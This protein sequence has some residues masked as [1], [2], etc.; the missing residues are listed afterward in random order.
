MSEW[1]HVVHS[2][3]EGD[4]RIYVNGQAKGV[5]SGRNSLLDVRRPGRMWVGGWYDNYSFVGQIDEVR[6][7]K[8]ARSAHWV[9]LAYENQKP[10]QTLVGMPVQP[11]TTLAVSPPEV[12]LDEGRSTVLKASAGGA[13]KIYWI[14]QRGR[15]S[16]VVATDTLSYTLP[17]ARV[18]ENTSWVLRLKAV[19]PDGAKTL[20]VPIQIQETIPEPLID[21]EAPPSWN[22]RDKIEIVARVRN[23]AALQAAGAG[24]VHTRWTVSGGAVI[25]QVAADRL[26][27]L[28][29]QYTGPIRVTAS[30]DNGGAETVAAATIQ[31]TEPKSD[32]WVD[33]T[34]AKDEKPEEG[35]FYARDDKNEGTLHYRGVL[36]EPAD[37]VFL[38]IYA[39]DRPF[40][41]QTQPPGPDRAYAFAAR[42][43]P[44]LIKY[45]VE[46]GTQTGGKETVLEQR[47]QPGLR[48]R[49]S[50]RRPVECLGYRH[51]R[52]LAAQTSDWIRSYGGPTG[53]G[54]GADWVRNRQEQAERAGLGRP[55]LWCM[56]VWKA[57]RAEQLAETGWWGMELAKRLVEKQQVPIFILNTAV[58]GTRIDEHQPATPDR[59]DLKTLY[60][61]MLWRL[62]QARLT[63]GIRAVIWHQGE[64]D[65]GSDG[66]TGGYGWE[67]YQQYFVDLSA[68]WK[69]DL[70]NIQR[71]YVFQIWPNACAMGGQRGSGDRLREV[72]RTLPRLYSNM[73]IVSTLG[74]KPPGP[75]H[76]PLEGWSQ[77]ARLLQPMLDQDFYGAV[78]TDSIS[79][80]DLR[81][82][83]YTGRQQDE[84]ALEFDQPVVWHEALASQFFLGEHGGEV[85][86]GRAQGNVLTLT[87]KR[88]ST[89][90]RIT[91]L[92]ERDW[93]Q[94]RLLLGTNGLAALTFCDVAI[95][96]AAP[97]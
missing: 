45:R 89:A 47:R 49:V 5:S 44:G 19:Y 23:L 87:L 81:K 59:H 4:S 56:P 29:S 25:K 24:E 50:H 6:I 35:Q 40:A 57:D 22:G 76:Y 51:R 33:P 21:L 69:Q 46:L 71:Y 20:E 38:K 94:D 64:N 85:V 68:A 10:Q 67:T 41:T 54:D 86:S 88:P 92:K 11:G 93:N 12:K 52:R 42:L 26:I 55:N 97:R 73:R 63:H 13:E 65:Q 39:D 9:R 15:S 43:K 60:G 7:S 36:A 91:Y 1:V 70:P 74:I 30:V 37:S 79:P 2:Y 32:P 78:P 8:V 80:P 34:P 84:I 83:S 48:R 17:A 58:G 66:P 75:C 61:R 62:E 27:L 72:Q 14:L 31:V 28:R 18:T 96:P 90:T 77:F 3:R 16:S 95:E 53:R 82:A